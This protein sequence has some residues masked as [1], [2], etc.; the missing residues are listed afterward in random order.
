MIDKKIASLQAQLPFLP[1]YSFQL[2]K[3]HATERKSHAFDYRNGVAI[4]KGEAPGIGGILLSGQEQK[5]IHTSLDVYQKGDSVGENSPAL[6]ASSSPACVP[7]WVVFDRKVLRF[8]A[9]F[10]EAV[11]E[12]REEKYRVRRVNI[13]FYL[14]DDSVHVSEPK[15]PN[16]GIPQGTLI[17]RHRIPKATSETNQH[18]TVSDFNVGS[19]V[20]FYSK[21]FKIIGCDMFTREFLKSIDIVAPENEDY[22]SDPYETQRNEMLGRMKATRPSIPNF[23]LKKFL[24]NDRRVLRF[25]CVWDD[26]NSVFGDVRHM[27]VHYFLSDDTVEIR[28][29]I[30]ANSGRETNTLFLRRCKLPRRPHAAHVNGRPGADHPDD[31]FGEHDFMIGSVLHLYDRPFVICDCDEFTKTYY[32][33]RYGVQRFDPVQFKS[34]PEEEMSP[35]P[36]F[37]AHGVATGDASDPSVPLIG[38]DPPHKKNFK[39]MVLYDGIKLR[40]LAVLKSTKQVDRDRKF[41]ISYHLSDDTISVFEPRARNSGILGGKFLEQRHI[42]KP[43]SAEFYESKDFSIGAE[44]TFYQHHFVIVGADDH[45]IKFM[46]LNP[47]LFPEH[48]KPAV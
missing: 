25:Y 33:E 30:P 45:A 41:V 24:E 14:E 38:N 43:N 8:Y 10:Q 5:T 23:S 48:V 9:Y 47:E 46:D 29:S 31:Y 22:P 44:L 40:F 7:A 20:T 11:H 26:S 34:H 6:D 4:F 27:V 35:L 18:Y 36:F 28:E 17:R 19:Q 3:K 1:G 15:T 37:D 13:Y 16:S 21:T 42:K 32:R 12:R 2:D 39:K